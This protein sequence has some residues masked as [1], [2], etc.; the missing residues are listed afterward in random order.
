MPLA[1]PALATLALGAFALAC[2]LAGPAALLPRAAG[3]LAFSV[4]ALRCCPPRTGT[5][6]AARALAGRDAGRR[7]TPDGLRFAPLGR[8]LMRGAEGPSERFVR[9]DL[10]FGVAGRFRY[11]TCAFCGTVF[12]DPQVAAADIGHL[13][14]ATYYTHAPAEPAAPCPAPVPA[15]AMAGARDRWRGALRDAIRGGGHGLARVLARSRSARQRAYFG[16][17]DELIPRASDR[18]A[19]EVGSGAGDLLMLLGQAGWPEVEGVDFDAAAAERA[20]ARSG[21]PVRSRRSLTSTC[22]R[23]PS[24]WSCSCTCPSTC[25]IHARCWRACASCSRATAARS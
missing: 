22:P 17:T 18:R 16:P 8:C 6:A 3:G 25:P 11:C 14:P 12:Q 2:H 20:R 19:L 4:A 10:W 15:R 24:T 7:V 1:L 9:E 13:Y 23:A 5:P 21:R